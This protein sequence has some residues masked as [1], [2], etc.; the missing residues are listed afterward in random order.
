MDYFIEQ[1]KLILPLV[2]I[3]SLVVATPHSGILIPPTAGL[4]EYSIKSNELNAT[5]VESDDGFVVRAGSEAASTTSKSIALGWLNIRKKL[6]DAG[7]LKQVG[8]RLVFSDDTTFS[9]PSAASSVI[10]GRQAPGPITWILPD[11]RT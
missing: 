9:S 2:G 5:M 1:I 6:I 7:V 10:L 8:D 3:R 4:R 11:G